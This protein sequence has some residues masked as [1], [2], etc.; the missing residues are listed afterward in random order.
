[1]K[2]FK[3]S[4]FFPIKKKYKISYVNS[5][6]K[7]RIIYQNI[8]NNFDLTDIS[9][10]KLLR[11]NSILFLGDELNDKNIKKNNIH[12]VT[13]NTNNKKYYKN[14]TIVDNLSDT[15]NKIVN[16]M[17][18]HEDQLGF[19]DEFNLINGSYVSIYSKIG[20][21]SEIGKNCFI[22]R[23]VEIGNNSIIKNNVVIKNSIIGNN[24][25]VCDNT[26]IGTT[27]FGFDFKLRGSQYI[28]PQI[29]IVF[30]DDNVHIGACC[31]VDR[32]KIDYTFI[33]KNSMI[34]NMVHI[35]HNTTIGNNACIAAQTGISGSVTIGN[36]VTIGG[37]VGF[38]GHIKIGD[39]VVIAARS[40]V[41]KNIKENSTV[42]GFPAIDIKEWKKNLIRQ[43][44]YGYK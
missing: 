7:D 33:G 44:R 25:V 22:A 37:K 38:A 15:Y 40:G 12:V 13:T 19:K 14:I 2:L 8:E 1:M 32:G 17:Y 41:T 27:G 26:S 42:A 31:T 21:S 29:G 34:D 20:S 36:N 10:L 18:F 35:G 3:R 43:K 30:I 23:G 24:V 16:E 39:N 4:N 6:L 5:L 11:D 9:S 28:N